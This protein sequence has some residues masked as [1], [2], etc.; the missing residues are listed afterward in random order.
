MDLLHFVAMVSTGGAAAFGLRAL[1]A[2]ELPGGVFLGPCPQ[3]AF[4]LWGSYTVGGP[5]APPRSPP[6]PPGLLQGWWPWAQPRPA[7]LPTPPAAPSSVPAALLG[8]G[9]RA[10]AWLRPGLWHWPRAPVPL[11]RCATAGPSPAVPRCPRA[12]GCR[13][14]GVRRCIPMA[15]G[16][17]VPPAGPR[18]PL[19]CARS[20]PAPPRQGRACGGGCFP[21]A[22][23]RLFPH[24]PPL[25]P[26]GAG[27]AA[28]PAPSSPSCPQRWAVPPWPRLDPPVTAAT[29]VPPKP[30]MPSRM[31]LSFPVSAAVGSGDSRGVPAARLAGGGG[32][33]VRTWGHPWEYGD[34][35]TW[36]HMP[37]ADGGHLCRCPEVG[38]CRAL[39]TPL[40]PRGC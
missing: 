20:L 13:W 6:W 19:S 1:P 2:P 29:V 3:W 8:S 23:S 10:G 26:R 21:R 27:A 34:V 7:L 11:R 30:H 17:C 12:V 16:A 25:C 5:R 37:Q 38:L 40:S 35:V 15:A 39:G 4:P 32:T 14:S 18:S 31:F 22:P 33:H 9:C 36:G 24:S 28:A